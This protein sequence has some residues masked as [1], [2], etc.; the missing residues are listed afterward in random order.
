MVGS[1]GCPSGSGSGSF[2]DG[3]SRKQ[4]MTMVTSKHEVEIGLIS[5]DD[6][7]TITVD[8]GDG[9]RETKKNA[10]LTTRFNHTYFD[11]IPHT[12]TIT[13]KDVR[14]L[15]CHENQ[16]TALDVSNNPMLE[17]LSC[18]ENLLT[19]LDVSK[20][21][22]LTG[23]VCS[24]NQFTAAALNAL[25][26]SLSLRRGDI[27]IDGNPGSY[28]CDKSIATRKGWTVHATNYF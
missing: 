10:V 28:D 18:S 15:G 11:A 23:M 4:S 13:A 14:W 21:P 12:I 2:G 7:G 20:N 17:E 26:G 22:A 27:F 24:N 1:V 8:W 3:S 6:D 5:Y 25:F 9:M 16:L 19:K